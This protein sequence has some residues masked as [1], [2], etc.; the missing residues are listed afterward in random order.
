MKQRIWIFIN[1]VLVALAITA[2][3]NYPPSDPNKHA[4]DLDA[5]ASYPNAQQ[6]TRTEDGNGTTWDRRTIKFRT[7]DS[8]TVVLAYYRDKMAKSGL[9]LL[10]LPKTAFNMLA[11]DWNNGV[12]SPGYRLVVTV[13]Q[14]APDQTNV[15]VIESQDGPE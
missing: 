15:E 2:C 14:V 10:D 9:Q 7:T 5:I 3:S 1:C 11:G 12:G 6:L 8:A 13:D 4:P